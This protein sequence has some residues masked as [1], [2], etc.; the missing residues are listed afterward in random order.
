M[1]LPGGRKM[2]RLRNLLI[3]IGI[4]SFLLLILV[5]FLNLSYLPRKGKAFVLKGL[6]EQTG[7]E[8]ELSRIAFNPLKGFVLKS[9]KLRDP[10]GRTVLFEVEKVT[11]QP[12]WVPL[13]F[14]NQFIASSVTL[15]K[16][17]FPLIRFA[18]GR[19]NF[20]ELFEKM[21]QRPKPVFFIPRITLHQG[22]L[23]LTDQ[24]LPTPL[25]KQVT[26]LNATCSM[27]FPAQLKV[28]GSFGLRGS[29]LLA[30]FT[31]SRPLRKEEW[32]L[33]GTLKQVTWSDL[34]PYLKESLPFL[35]SARGD[36]SFEAHYDTKK[37]LT[38][39]QIL[40]SGKTEFR[41]QG[42]KGEATLHLTGRLFYPFADK[43]KWNCHFKARLSDGNLEVP[44][45]DKPF[46]KM[47][48]ELTFKKEEFLLENIQA[49]LGR[50]P[51]F[52]K[53]KIDH[54]EDPELD[55]SLTS[56]TD[57]QTFLENFPKRLLDPT[58]LE[59]PVALEH[60]LKGKMNALTTSGTLH[61]KGLLIRIPSF[62]TIEA[63]QGAVD[64]T[65]NSLRTTSLTGQYRG[66]P[67]T[68][69]GTL[70]D[71]QNPVLDLRLR[72]AQP[73]QEIRN[74]PF[75]NTIP[76][77]MRPSSVAGAGQWD[78]AIKGPLQT[79]SQKE[80]SGSCRLQNASL[81]IPLLPSP[82]NKMEGEFSFDAESLRV[83]KM[84]G[85]YG[86]NSFSL[87]GSFE[88]GEAPRV[89]FS[90]T[91]PEAQ[92]SSRFTLQGKN[93]SPFSLTRRTSQSSLSVEGEIL[94]YEEPTLELK[95]RW[96]G[97]LEELG[98]LKLL[99][100]KQLLPDPLRGR[101]ETEFNL[102][103]PKA[104]P[105]EMVLS[106]TLS[107]PLLTYKKLAFKDVSTQ[108]RYRQKTLTLLQFSSRFLGGGCAGEALFS[109]DAKSY[110]VHLELAK[111]PLKDLIQQFKPEWKTSQGVLSGLLNAEGV[112]G[113]LGTLKGEGWVEI[114]EGDLFQLP[115]LKGLTPVLRPIVSTLYPELDERI[116][117]QE[118]TAHFRVG[119]NLITTENLI[120]KGDRA[121][122]YGQGSI[123][124]NQ[125]VDFRLGLR[126]T[127]PLI[128]DRST[129]LS[130]LK[131]ILIDE[132]GMLSGEVRVSGTLQ[133]P[134]YRYAPLPLN[135]LKG[136]FQNIF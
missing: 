134:K 33:N 68:L 9:F 132:I 61:A 76:E 35:E 6:K 16:P 24:T 88:K 71:F 109:L 46:R 108:V 32:S 62:G 14:K 60:R 50:A 12:L 1:M 70:T 29:P 90:L 67:L 19:W 136:I 128:L 94:N 41:G 45:V 69:E 84:T 57:I 34:S 114:K 80:F 116:V 42:F 133:E 18:N 117:F 51:V 66:F 10:Q 85:L 112:S 120:L 125:V 49:T 75:W 7:L 122:L 30:A 95:G 13:F 101:L 99:G 72:F 22:N 96:E 124:L 52:L 107:S 25:V 102:S 28:K 47:T 73:L 83:R 21:G 31:A 81:E 105:E 87:E 77:K 126:F 2:K 8:A 110:Q 131:N 74:F 63:L 91:T 78:L 135:R 54:F 65:Q 82:V 55:L 129:K 97:P 123:G 27:K 17:S 56:E 3:F 104:R 11:V 103:G 26:A 127:D 106:G 59:G 93:L 98:S 48:G 44:F 53:G 86:G 121:T 89:A 115:L 118:A 79:F 40:F 119:Q 20:Q 92:L 130:H 23:L 38:L 64:F 15:E 58:T 43:E 100:G 113:D 37:R 5:L 36:L 4:L 39:N 111:I